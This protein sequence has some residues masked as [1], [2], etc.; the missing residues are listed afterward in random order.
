MI[1]KI[2]KMYVDGRKI[3]EDLFQEIIFQLWKSYQ[4]FEGKSQFSTW[5]YKGKYQTALTF[6]KKK[7]ENR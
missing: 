3:G 5:L 6:L 7:K 4:N 1:F 2:S